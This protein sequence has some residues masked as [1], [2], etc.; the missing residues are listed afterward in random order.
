M[1][2]KIALTIMFVA[3]CGGSKEGAEAAAKKQAAELEA[4]TTT[5]QPAQ[6]IHVP[7]QNEGHIPC[8]QLIPDPAV[9][10]AALGE[11]DPVTVMDNGK[12]D[13]EAAAVCAIMKGG[14]PLT[15]KQQEALAKKTNHRLGIQPNDK[16]CSVT[17]Y[18]WTV[19]TADGFKARCAQKGLQ[20]DQSMGNYA[21]VQVI[22][23]GEKDVNVYS[24]YDEDTKCVLKVNAGPSN[25]D[26]DKIRICAET[27][28]D[29]I[30]PA[31]IAVDAPPPT[32]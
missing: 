1:R 18:C 17:A 29:T 19:E 16:I 13:A 28:R 23:T 32:P 20:D 21:C 31:Q 4:K 22:K 26:N 11:V 24:F 9:Y 14:V 2:G 5:P 6:K 27:A 3:A 8:E 15:P 25:T 30:G 7:V 12:A 10:Q